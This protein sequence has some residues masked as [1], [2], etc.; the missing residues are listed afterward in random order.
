MLCFPLNPWSVGTASSSQSA[1]LANSRHWNGEL[2]S[3]S[4]TFIVPELKIISFE[5][6][7]LFSFS[8]PIISRNNYIHILVL[9]L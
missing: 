5:I 7:F 1:S 8:P 2:H 6:F 9:P 4:G 3:D